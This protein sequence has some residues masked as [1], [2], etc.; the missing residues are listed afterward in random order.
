M[1]TDVSLKCPDEGEWLAVVRVNDGGETELVSYLNHVPDDLEDEIQAIGQR[2]VE[3][4]TWPKDQEIQEGARIREYVKY[5]D[6]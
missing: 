4:W 6:E 3:R 1:W 2:W 5:P